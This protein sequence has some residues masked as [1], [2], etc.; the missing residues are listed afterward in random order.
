M[1][2]EGRFH[3]EGCGQLT[4]VSVFDYLDGPKILSFISAS[5]QGFLGYWVEETQQAETWLLLPLS[6]Q[7]LADLVDG[8]VDLRTALAAPESAALALLSFTRGKAQ[9]ETR[10]LLSGHPELESLLPVEGELLVPTPRVRVELQALLDE[11]PNSDLGTLVLEPQER[12]SIVTAIART[13][14]D[15]LSIGRDLVTVRFGTAVHEIGSRVLA[16]FL[17]A[18]QIAVDAFAHTQAETLNVRAV[19]PGSFNLQ[20]VAAQRPEGLFGLTKAAEGL[21]ALFE[22]MDAGPDLPQ[23]KRRLAAMPRLSAGRYSRIISA[24]DRAETTATFV[25]GSPSVTQPE[26]RIA[27][28]TKVSV[29]LVGEALKEFEQKDKLPYEVDGVLTLFGGIKRHSFEL[30]TQSGVLSG[31]YDPAVLDQVSNPVYGKRYR[32]RIIEKIKIS[33]AGDEQLIRTMVGLTRI[34]EED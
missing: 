16:E 33:V 23:L 25:W 32:A 28:F 22:L 20:L 3:L 10:W 4:P 6:P 27:G 12:A 17:R 31:K 14:S 13:K 24:L 26:T 8:R 2:P 11:H 19:P 15:A 30:L 5:G 29:G 21:G 7:R 1:T 9:P 34:V 18:F